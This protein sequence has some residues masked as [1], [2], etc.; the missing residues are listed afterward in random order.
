MVC[1][2]C[3]ASV[4]KVLA[5]LGM[6][7]IT[8]DL[9]EATFTVPRDLP[10]QEALRRIDTALTA[11]GFERIADADE[12]LVDNIKH[13]VISH[14]RDEVECKY[15]L[16]A[17][18]A[19]H[20]GISYDQASRVFSRLE[21]RTIE[22]YHIL[23][24]VEYVKEMLGYGNMNLAEIA[25]RAGYSSAAHL[26]RQFKEVTGMTPTQY[27]ASGAKLRRPLDTV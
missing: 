10:E 16:S 25:D 7:D 4:E 18:I 14:V 24:K 27:I 26:S 8:V 15:N 21:G 5:T 9:G 2:H 12:I 19:S 6:T 11:N 23:Q 22:R 3:V 17:C 20:I 1:R 13:A